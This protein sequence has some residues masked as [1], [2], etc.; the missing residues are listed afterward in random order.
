M[1]RS[2][3]DTKQKHGDASIWL[4]TIAAPLGGTDTVDVAKLPS[5][6]IFDY[7]RYYELV[8]PVY[9]DTTKTD[10]M[11]TTPNAANPQIIVDNTDAGCVFSSTWSTSYS[12]PG[13]YGANYSYYSTTSSTNWAKWSPIIPEDGNY[14]IYMRWAAY[15]NRPTAVPIEIKHMEGVSTAKVDQ[16][17]NGGKWNFL[18]SYQLNKGQLNYVKVFCSG[19]GNTIADA[20]LF[21]KMPVQTAVQQVSSDIARFWINSNK[22]ENSIQ[23][24]FDIM[25]NS[26]V[27]LK[28]YTIYGTL[29]SDIINN[30]KCISG[31]HTFNIA[32]SGI[33][34]GLY[35]ALLTV[36]NQV[37]T[38][39]FRCL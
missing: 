2:L 1:V 5:A 13:F 4:T 27:S 34:Q 12:I 29:V 28:I 11:L 20:V 30:E 37:M 10:S 18:G 21:E 33:N 38:T 25:K 3:D 16:T 26:V 17:Q 14:R 23:A 22:D 7:V 19:G 15:T 31:K 36:D 32:K 6:A 35:F 8:N 24:C 39:K 9:P